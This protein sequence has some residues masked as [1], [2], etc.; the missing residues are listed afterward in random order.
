MPRG[1]RREMATFAANSWVWLADA[2][3]CFIPVKVKQA[4]KAGEPGVV[5]TEEGQ[6]GMGVGG[7]RSAGWARHHPNHRHTHC[8]GHLAERCVASSLLLLM[9]STVSVLASSRSGR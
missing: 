5:L 8:S 6:V 4:F 2:E 1:S 3:E 9:V 7:R